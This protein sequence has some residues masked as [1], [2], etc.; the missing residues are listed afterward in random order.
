MQFHEIVASEIERLKPL[1]LSLHHHHKSVAPQL[2]PFVDDETSWANRKR[3]YAEVFAG[4]YFGNIASIDG[5]DV[6]Y[7]ICAKRPM[8]WQATFAIPSMLWEL[9][10]IVVV[11]EQRG[12]GV[13][14][15]LLDAMDDHIQTSDS[16]TQLIGVI[17]NN[18]QAVSLYKRRGLVPGWI[19][20]TR[21]QRTVLVPSRVHS[22][23]ITGIAGEDDMEFLKPLWISLHHHHQMVSPHL[24]P[25]VDD[26]KSWSIIREMFAKSARDGLLLIAR[27]ADEAVGLA[28][29]AIFDMNDSPMWTDTLITDD[30]VAETKFLVVCDGVRGKGIGTALMAAVDAE[31]ARRGVRDHFIG[32]IAPNANAIRFINRWDMSRHG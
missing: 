29:L 12:K 5:K 13:G 9:V 21:F 3:Q 8:Q 26:E 32:A 6:G 28:S 20:L 23:V 30:L 10:T 1:W 27:D 17:P 18:E 16:Q 2:A 25:W 24:G 11:P 7:L 31:L 4:E 19:I 15:L 22:S 14:K